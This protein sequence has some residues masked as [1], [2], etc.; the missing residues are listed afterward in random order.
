[1]RQSLL[2]PSSL[3]LIPRTIAGIFLHHVDLFFKWSNLNSW[4]SVFYRNF[5][6]TLTKMGITMVLI[7]VDVSLRTSQYF[8]SIL[9]NLRRYE[10][11]GLSDL[12]CF[13]IRGK[14][15]TLTTPFNLKSVAIT[16]SNLCFA[17]LTLRVVC[18]DFFN[19]TNLKNN[20]YFNWNTYCLFEI[21]TTRIFLSE[22]SR[23]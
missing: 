17:D 4:V 10:L 12:D 7:C 18:K 5:G 16:T 3:S 1:M 23:F 6:Y 20:F 2:W 22:S 14:Y 9:F 21:N 15:L 8:L 19:Y 13:S 11:L